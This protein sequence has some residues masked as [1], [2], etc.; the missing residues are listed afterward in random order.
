MKD[1]M[2]DKIIE[3][4]DKAKKEYFNDVTDHTE[5]EYIVECLLNYGVV[6]NHPTEKGGGEEWKLTDVD[7]CGFE[8]ECQNCNRHI[9]VRHKYVDLPNECPYCRTKLKGGEW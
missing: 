7:E 5:T 4:V 2:R 3:L 1:G 6:L 8:Y 9:N